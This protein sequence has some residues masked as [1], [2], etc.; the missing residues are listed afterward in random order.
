MSYPANET[1]I[2]GRTSQLAMF[3]YQRVPSGY[4]K[5]AIENDNL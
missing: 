4:V 3:D 5:I 2:F 1:S